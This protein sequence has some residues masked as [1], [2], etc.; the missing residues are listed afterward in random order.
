MQGLA[1]LPRSRQRNALRRFARRIGIGPPAAPHVE[2]ILT[3]LLDAREDAAP[4]VSWPGGEARRFRDSVYLMPPLA[5]SPLR[6][7][8]WTG[9]R[10][11]QLGE[12]LGRLSLERVEHEALDPGLLR[13]G[14][15]VRPRHGGEQIRIESHGPT[16]KLKKLLN[17]YGVVPWMRD[18]LPLLYAGD[19]LVAV[20]DLW[21]AADARQSPGLEV[22]WHDGPVLT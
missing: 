8:P 10:P 19:R 17:E 12:E 4:L 3:T 21:V 5:P 7:T 14:L 20:A 1:A 2:Q 15:V 9:A 16:R 6:E 11:L 13:A 22:R 18:R